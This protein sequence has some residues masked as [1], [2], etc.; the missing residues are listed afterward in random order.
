MQLASERTRLYVDGVRSAITAEVAR[1]RH[2]GMVVTQA[3]PFLRLDTPVLDDAGTRARIARVAISMEGDVPRLL[4][5]LVHEESP[6]LEAPVTPLGPDDTLES[7]TPGVS[8]RPARTDSTVPYDFQR[9]AEEPV[10]IPV[11]RE[12]APAALALEPAPAALALARPSAREPFWSALV[13]R[14]RELFVVWTRRALAS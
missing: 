5:E 8:S 6:A 13:R 14:V 12:P 3:L 7:F 10:A 1:R 11:P 4:L 2:G 9:R